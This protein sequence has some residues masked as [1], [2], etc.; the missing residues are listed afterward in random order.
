MELI[1]TAVNPDHIKN[2]NKHLD[3]AEIKNNCN[4]I[5]DQCL[6]T[7]LKYHN[8]KR[9][10]Y[11]RNKREYMG[12]GYR[13][14]SHKA[15]LKK[16]TNDNTF[17][18]P[19]NPGTPEGHRSMKLHFNFINKCGHKASKKGDVDYNKHTEIVNKPYKKKSVNRN[20]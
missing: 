12:I 6:I 4:D 18:L 8:T 7:L 16:E 3:K 14:Q 9:E 19:Q 2:L 5:D 17:R 11:T 1:N 20:S 10:T 13:F 15:K